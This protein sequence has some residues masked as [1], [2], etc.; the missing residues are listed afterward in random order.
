MA[1]TSLAKEIKKIRNES[2]NFIIIDG[3]NMSFKYYYGLALLKSKN[4]IKTGIYH[5]FLSLIL[6]LKEKYPGSKIIIAWEGDD[7]IRK[8]IRE[9][10][11]ANREAKPDNLKKSILKLKDL[12]ALLGICQKFAPG[13]EADDIAAYY[14]ETYKGKYKILLVSEDGDWLQVMN[15]NCSVFKKNKEFSYDCLEDLN[16]Y[17]P[18]R[19]ILYKMIKGDPKDNILGIPY[20]PVELA[21]DITKNCKNLEEAFRFVPFNKSYLKWVSSL[22][23]Y[24]SLI[25]DNYEILKLRSD[26]NLEDLPCHEVKNLSK[27]K[28]E[29]IKLQLYKVLNQVRKS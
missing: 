2:Y 13:Y 28:A 3:M 14:C 5:G 8:K 20:F 21:K 6:R 10:Y 26:I 29:L 15:K 16:G 7:L 9:S 11:K 25:T 17:P 27:L 24:K 19:V 4:G 18:E 22:E 23:D 1:L 12:L